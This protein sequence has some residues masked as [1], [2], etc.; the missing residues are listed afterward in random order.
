MTS[1]LEGIV[2]IEG[3]EEEELTPEGREV[4]DEALEEIRRRRLL[5][6]VV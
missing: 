1:L 6:Y 5:T 3:E 2:D 4:L